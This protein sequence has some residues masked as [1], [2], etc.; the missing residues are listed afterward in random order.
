M[1]SLFFFGWLARNFLATGS[2][3]SMNMLSPVINGSLGLHVNNYVFSVS[4]AVFSLFFCH[5]FCP[6]Q[7]DVKNG[8]S[9]RNK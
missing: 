6:R 9:A 4:F 8:L 5:L 2:T 3:S 1:Y 7:S